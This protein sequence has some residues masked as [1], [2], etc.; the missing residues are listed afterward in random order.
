MTTHCSAPV[1]S[2]GDGRWWRWWWGGGRVTRAFT[3]RGE[4]VESR[5]S[6]FEVNSVQM[7]PNQP[8][9]H[10]PREEDVRRSQ[11]PAT[12]NRA[13]TTTHRVVV[14]VLFFFFSPGKPACR[15]ALEWL[16]QK[17]Y[18]VASSSL[19]KS[20]SW[21]LHSGVV[22]T[23]GGGRTEVCLCYEAAGRRAKADRGLPQATREPMRKYTK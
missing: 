3:K 23:C 15:L 9:K 4:G 14:L 12:E 10:K 6:L 2:W 21:S 20:R 13:T 22:F 19:K 11:S 5:G 18:S 1:Y 8:H 7:G 17:C 16:P